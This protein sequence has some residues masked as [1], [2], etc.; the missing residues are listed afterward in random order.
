MGI[1]RR[2]YKGRLNAGQAADGISAAWASARNL[3][4]AAEK[5]LASG[6]HARATAL[7]VLAIEEAGKAPIIRELL[8]AEDGR[9]LKT[10][11]LRYRQHSSKNV[12]WIL[13]QLVKMGSEIIDDF[14]AIW[15]P[16]SDHPAFIEGVKQMALYSDAYDDCEWSIP[17]N[18]I[19]PPLTE[20]L[21]KV[22]RLLISRGPSAMSTEPEL[23]IWVKHMRPVWS[24][25]TLEELKRAFADCYQEAHQAGVLTGNVNV[26]DLNGFV[27]L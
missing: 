9:E 24:E 13:P 2:Q 18:V 27:S 20:E 22:A 23:E 7:A 15:D 11:W 19:E 17:S 4:S 12:L 8:L 21:L 26:D 3:L 5:L 25:G 16:E 1:R 6:D 14:R 10:A